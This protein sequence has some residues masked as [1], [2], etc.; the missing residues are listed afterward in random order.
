MSIA[1]GIIEIVGNVFFSVGTAGFTSLSNFLC[2]DLVPLKW[3]GMSQGLLSSSYII[4]P[5]YSDHIVSAL[6]TEDK[7]RWVYGM[8]SIL[9]PIIIG[10]AVALLFRLQHN[11]VKKGVI[12]DIVAHKAE[13]GRKVAALTPDVPLDERLIL[14]WHELDG[15]G[16][17]LLGFG[18]FLILLPFSLYSGVKGGY[19]NPSLIAMFVVGALCLIVSVPCTSQLPPTSAHRLTSP[20]PWNPSKFFFSTTPHRMVLPLLSLSPEFHSGAL[21]LPT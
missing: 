5:W 19:N 8:Y 4:V 10:P 12:A 14:I 6:S 17:L 1:T 16:L 3:R 18:W 21:A 13:E 2:A 11:A 15:W 20:Q 7:W 9:M